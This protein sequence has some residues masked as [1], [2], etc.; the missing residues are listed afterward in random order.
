MIPSDLIRL[1]LRGLILD[2][3]SNAPVVL[4]REA[5]SDTFLPIW[6]GPFEAIAI[7]R[8]LEGTKAARPQT[9]DLA[10]LIVEGLGGVLER[11]V[12]RALEEGT[13]L[14]ALV[15][16]VGDRRVE[17]DARPSDA[18]ALAVRCDAPILAS[19]DVLARGR[20]VP[21]EADESEEDRIKRLLESLAPDDFG[22]TM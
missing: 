19:Q 2:P 20:V 5:D 18:I 14:G 11:V 9:H 7:S 4:L 16:A 21:A 6:I 3:D 15:V 13:F 22:Y 12:I 8:A 1:E 17:I 10:L